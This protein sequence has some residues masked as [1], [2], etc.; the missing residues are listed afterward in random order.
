MYFQLKLL[1]R[2]VTTRNRLG[3]NHGKCGG[4][5]RVRGQPER[6]QT[7][8]G[9]VGS[10]S[11]VFGEEEPEEASDMMEREYPQGC[12]R[13]GEDEHPNRTDPR[14]RTQDNGTTTTMTS[15][16]I[17]GKIRKNQRGLRIHQ[18]RMKCLAAAR[19]AQRTKVTSGQT[20]EE[21]GL[22][23]THSARSL[24]VSPTPGPTAHMPH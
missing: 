2:P 4:I 24:P 17:C 5:W 14:T 10:P 6:R 3:D 1:G 15:Q 9:R 23:A 12:P 13:G 18:G 7:R 20:E 11:H 8:L 22:E 19:T 16:C 21:P